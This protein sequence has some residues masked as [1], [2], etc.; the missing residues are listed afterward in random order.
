MNHAVLCALLSCAAFALSG[1]TIVKYVDPPEPDPPGTGAQKKVIDALVLVEIERDTVQL[2]PDYQAILGMLTLALQKSNVEIRKLAI[3]PMYRRSGA[4]VPL[5]YGQ[6]DPDAEFDEPG[7]A[8]AFFARDGGE[9]YLRDKA[10]S[11]GENL[12]TLGQDLDTRAIYHPETAD[13]NARTY[14][15]TPEDGFLVIQM[16]SRARLCAYDS[17]P[18]KLDGVLPADYFTRQDDRGAQWLVLPGGVSLPKGKIFFLNIATAEGV[19]EEDFVKA[20]ERQPGFNQTNLDYIEPSPNAYFGPFADRVKSSGSWSATL[21][22]CEAMSPTTAAP[23]IGTI[24]AQIRGKL[25][26]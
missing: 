14:F 25:G 16:T 21:D 4:S 8:I 23:K 18:C 2:A 20:C 9:R 17:E 12:A 19:G 15:T 5:I 13:T 1:C 11:E 26:R 24:A 6:G 7:E 22:M 3:A 10:D